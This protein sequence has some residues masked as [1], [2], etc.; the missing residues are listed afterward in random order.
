[1]NYQAKHTQMKNAIDKAFSILEQIVVSAPEACLP[2]TLAQKLNLNRAT[3]SRLIKQLCDMDYLLKVSRNQGYVPGP[4]LLAL[5]S[6][7]GFERQLLA[8]AQPVIDR[9]AE[10]L[11]CSVLLARLYNRRRYVLYHRN[12]SADMD[13]HLSRPYYNDLFCTATGLLL[14]AHLPEEERLACWQEQMN[15]GTEFLPEYQ[16]K[17]KLSRNLDAIKERGYFDCNRDSQ[18]IYAYPVFKGESFHAALGASI[19]SKSHNA[20]YHRRIG[21]TLK[22]AA[23]E[24]SANFAHQYIIE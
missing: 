3:C 1:M 6:I 22:Q 9:C 10:A 21:R 2:L 17:S 7:A 12:C 18:W 11:G 15:L 14:T 19:L 20:A 5:N 23:E 13:I 4:K 16:A 8:A 24:I